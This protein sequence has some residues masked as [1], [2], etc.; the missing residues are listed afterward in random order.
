[1]GH[2]FRYLRLST[3][4]SSQSKE[5]FYYYENSLSKFMVVFYAVTTKVLVALLAMRCALALTE[6][7]YVSLLV[8]PS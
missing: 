5:K 3:K 6:V 7:D 4:D 1:M 2:H 8:V